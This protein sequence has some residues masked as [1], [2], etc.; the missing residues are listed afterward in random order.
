MLEKIYGRTNWSNNRRHLTF[1][2][3][4]DGE[5]SGEAVGEGGD[6]RRGLVL[7]DFL[8]RGRRPRGT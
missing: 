8:W 6:Q 7:E 4:L 1:L 5:W 2:L 3:H